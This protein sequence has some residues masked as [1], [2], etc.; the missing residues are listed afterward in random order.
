MCLDDLREGREAHTAAV[1]EAP[2]LPPEDVGRVFGERLAELPDKARLPHAGRRRPAWPSAGRRPVER[3]ASAGRRAR[4]SG[5]R[6]ARRGV[7]P[8]RAARSPPRRGPARVCLWQRRARSVRTR[9]SGSSRGGSPL[10][11]RC[12]PQGGLLETERGDDDVPERH[13]LPRDLGVEI[14]ERLAG[15]DAD[16]DLQVDLGITL[17]QLLDRTPGSRTPR[18]PRVPGRRRR[19]QGRRRAPSR[20]RRC[21]SRRDR[22]IA[23]A[24]SERVWKYGA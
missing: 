5:R 18:G 6:A 17:V 11:R 12:R 19:R 1:G 20:R 13:P 24:R 2:S 21:T 15:V 16:A 8:G 3:P 23:R 9:S 10:P 22:R 4:R 14:D 7:R